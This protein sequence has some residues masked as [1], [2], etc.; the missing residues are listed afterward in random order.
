MIHISYEDLTLNEQNSS[1]VT[2]WYGK[3]FDGSIR[4]GGTDSVELLLATRSSD[5]IDRTI[6]FGIADLPKWSFPMSKTKQRL[7]LLALVSQVPSSSR[8]KI[9]TDV[10]SLGVLGL[11]QVTKNGGPLGIH[12][13]EEKHRETPVNN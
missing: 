13:H 9:L 6:G 7:V 10:R 1:N 2:T 3:M 12:C 8:M 4:W 5:F 11:T